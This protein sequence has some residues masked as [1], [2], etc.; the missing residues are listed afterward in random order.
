MYKNIRFEG[1]Q[2]NVR[3]FLIASDLYIMPSLFEGISITTI[4]AMA[5]KIPAILYDVPGLKDFNNDGENSILIKEDYQILEKTVISIFTKQKNTDE[6][7]ASAINFVNSNYSM[8]K[9]VEH[10]YNLYL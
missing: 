9:N 5:C 3:K 7:I 6:M 1:N 4:E 10:I 2:N 8:K